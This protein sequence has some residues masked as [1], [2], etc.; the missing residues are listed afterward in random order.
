M[1]FDL[2]SH[3]S[4]SDG[5]LAPAAL[6][7]RAL[8]QGVQ[9]LAIT[10][11]DSVDGVLAACDSELPVA[12]VPGVELSCVWGKALVHIV[13]LNIDPGAEAMTAG[14]QQ[15]QQARLR[16]AHLIGEKLAKAGFAGACE[17]AL[18]LAAGSQVGRP[19]FAR[20]LVDRGFVSSE[21]EAF[22]KFLGAGKAGDVKLVWPALA[23]VVQWIVDSGGVAVLAHPLH[24][25]MTA[26]KLRGL[27]ADFKAAGGRAVEVINGR[28]TADRT[29]TLSELAKRFELLASLGSDFH[30]PGAP[31]SELGQMGSL[32]PDVRPVWSAWD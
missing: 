9:Q 17:G 15:Q 14:L 29:R 26:T 4:A 2:H 22:K 10:D 23:E 30:A 25:R 12:L 18:A 20:F 16:R 19:H 11:H 28:Q 27:C 31:W 7:Q 24:Y 32:P 13:G 5:S 1:V 6:L 8:Q 3:S 21:Q